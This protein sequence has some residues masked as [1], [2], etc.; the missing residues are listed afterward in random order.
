MKTLRKTP[1]L[2]KVEEP[3]DGLGGALQTC[4]QVHTDHASPG[5]SGSGFGA[6]LMSRATGVTWL[7]SEFPVSLCSVKKQNNFF[8]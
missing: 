3:G 7:V 2:K 6:R 8:G 1:G 4:R 5:Q